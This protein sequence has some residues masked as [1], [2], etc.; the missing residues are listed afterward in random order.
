MYKVVKKL[1]KKSSFM[2]K[3]FGTC[4]NQGA[5]DKFVIDELKK[6]PAGEVLLDAGSGAQRYRNYCSHLVYKAQD[7]GEFEVDLVPSY[8]GHIK[9][10]QYGK[11]DYTGNIWSIDERAESFDVILCTEVLEHVPYPNETIKEFFRL[12]KKGGKLILTA[13]SNCLRHMDPYYFY[14]GFSDRWFSEFLLKNG[15]LI[16]QMVTVG[17]FNSW[18]RAIVGGTLS[19][20]NLLERLFLFPSFVYFSLKNKTLESTASLCE[21][22]YL[23]AYKK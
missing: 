5:R 2:R 8:S 20:V 16:D 13:P 19:R 14:S 7:F 12:L 18:M 3:I 23:V 9:K 1:L 21:G 11:L 6:I 4:D 17:D 10:F 15:F 22:Y